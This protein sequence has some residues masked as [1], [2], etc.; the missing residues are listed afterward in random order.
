MEPAAQIVLQIPRFAR[1]DGKFVAFSQP[2][3]VE[4]PPS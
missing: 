4:V 1:N 3:A 2:D